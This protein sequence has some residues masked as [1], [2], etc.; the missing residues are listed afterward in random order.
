M[1]V[2]KKGLRFCRV[3]LLPRRP[4]PTPIPK[5][6]KGTQESPA[7]FE[8]DNDGIG[9]NARRFSPMPI[10]DFLY[11]LGLYI[12]D[13]H[14]QISS[15]KQFVKEVGNEARGR[16]SKTGRF[17]YKDIPAVLEEYASYRTWFALPQNSLP[18]SKLIAVLKKNN[19]IYGVTPTQVWVY[20]KPFYLA[21]K[22]C[23]SSAYAKCIPP[24]ILDYPNRPLEILLEGLMDSD[25]ALRGRYY[26]VSKK[27]AEQILEL[28][29]KLGKNISLTTRPVRTAVRR[30]GIKIQSSKSYEVSI[31]GNGRHWLNGAKFKQVD[32]AGKVWC[33]DVPG[34]HNL[35]VERNGRFIFCGNTKHGDGATDILPIGGL[36]KKEV[37]SLAESLGIPRHI[38]T[39]APS[40]GLWQGQ[41]DEGEMGITYNELDD[42]LERLEKNKRQVLS[43][44]KVDKVKEMISKSQHKRE[45]PKICRI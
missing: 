8:F 42:I 12:G 21:M 30:D 3:D 16:D 38:I 32:Y 17:I 20:G 37:R 4:T 6:W 33:P 10:E 18:R 25:G 23:G 34:A 45:G 5:P 36:L 1:L 26:T 7:F 28:G 14:A 35:L 27:L 40:A 43:K 9:I 19:I 39:K 41:T 13:G 22:K 2:D 15:V 24:E 11:I 29:C 31:Y 44:N